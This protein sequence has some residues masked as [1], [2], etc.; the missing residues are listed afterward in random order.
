MRGSPRAAGAVST[1]W[2]R[3]RRVNGSWNPASSIATTAETPE[4]A[5]FNHDA[6]LV[7]NRSRDRA[8]WSQSACAAF[9]VSCSLTNKKQGDGGSDERRRNWANGPAHPWQIQ[10]RGGHYEQEMGHGRLLGSRFRLRPAM[11]AD[12]RPEE[13]P[14]AHH[15]PRAEGNA[16]QRHRIRQEAPVPAQEFPD[17]G[18]ARAARPAGAEGTRRH[19]PEPRCRRHGGRDHRALRLPL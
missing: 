18:E 8:N 3:W 15:R 17:P 13:D 14:G 4:S 19:G 1:M 11:A 16:R 5:Q 10:S 2:S 12:R 6:R 9:A 7:W